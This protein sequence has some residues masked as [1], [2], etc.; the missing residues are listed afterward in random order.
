MSTKFQVILTG[1]F[2]L[3]IVVGVIVFSA[4]R[5]SDNEI[6]KIKVWGTL[7]ESD[8]QSILTASGLSQNE[9]YFIEYQQKNEQT[10]DNDLLEAIAAAEGPDIFLLPSNKIYKNLNKIFVVPYDVFTQRDFKDTFIE[11]SEIFMVPQGVV[12]LPVFVDPLVMYWN[13]SIFNESKVTLPPKYWDQF[14]NLASVISIKDGSLNIL[15]SAVSL[16]EYSN[17][18]HAKEIISTLAMQAGT[19]ITYWDQGILLTNFA[20]NLN[21]PIIP[22]E[23]AV[24]FYTEFSNPSKSSYSWNRSLAPSTNYFLSGDLAIYFGFASEIS[25]L[26]S[27][28]PNLNFDVASVPVS[29]EGGSDF[30]FGKFYGLAITKGSRNPN[31]A[32]AVISLL[33]S[34]EGSRAFSDLL[35]LPPVRRDLLA[36]RQTGA[37]KSVFYNSAIRARAWIDPDKDETNLIFKN[38]IESVTSGRS[39][40]SEAVSRASREI[41]NLIKR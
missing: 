38:M 34:Q 24:N 5:G 1:I 8:F 35:R 32:F 21:K 37:Y 16:G 22:A 27:K 33:T 40:V 30:V 29:R 12:A 7:A 10:F 26:Q 18:S 41:N 14:F 25:S 13:R 23:A 3:F 17:I 19:S 39:R 20:D 28:N 9:K 31:A 11:G 6:Y 4:Y 15:R 2:G 36:V